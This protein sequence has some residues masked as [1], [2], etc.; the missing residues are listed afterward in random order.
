[1]TNQLHISTRLTILFTTSTSLL[2]PP[3]KAVEQSLNTSVKHHPSR[4]VV[5]RHTHTHT[6]A[7]ALSWPTPSVLSVRIFYKLKTVAYFQCYSQQTKWLKIWQVTQLSHFRL[8]F[9]SCHLFY[10]ITVIRSWGRKVGRKRGGLGLVVHSTMQLTH[11]G[12]YCYAYFYII[13]CSAFPKICLHPH[14][15]CA[16]YKS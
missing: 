6:C 3:F 9:S 4:R 13:H 11:F 2:K 1:M 7:H 8:P 16:L 14:T 12:T 5:Y 10:R 15:T